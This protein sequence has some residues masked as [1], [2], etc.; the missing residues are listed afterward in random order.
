MSQRGAAEEEEE[1][2]ESVCDAKPARAEAS[3][4]GRGVYWSR[5]GAGDASDDAG[6]GMLTVGCARWRAGARWTCCT[7]T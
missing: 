2:I 7:R 3:T 5:G 1:R 4:S 6:R